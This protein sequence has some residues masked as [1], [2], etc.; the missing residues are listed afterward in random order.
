VR[1]ALGSFAIWLGL[2]ASITGIVVL[3][4]GL[5]RRDATLLRRGRLA[6]FAVCASG[7][8]ATI[9][10]QWALATDDFSLRYLAEHHAR[11]TEFPF[12]VTTM[13]SAL[14]G[15]ILLWLLVL[16]T[17]LTAMVVRFRDRADDA[18]VAWATL[19]GLV[20]A[21]FFEFLV[22]AAANPFETVSPVPSDGPG[23]NPLLQ[24]H[25]LVTLHPP[26]LYLGYVGFTIPF[27]FAIGAL[28]TGRVGEGWLVATRRATLIAWGFLT[29]G[30]ILGGWWS[31]EVLGWGGF[32]AWDPVEN[33]SLL[34]WLTATAFLHS[35]VVQER[36]GMLRVWNLSLVVATFALTIFGTFL[37]RS[38]V[39]KSVHSFSSGVGPWLM[40]FF[41]FVIVVSVGLIAWRGDR[42][43]A[44]GRIDA[45]VSREAAFLGNNLLFAA[46]AF[47]VLLGTT[48]PL[49]AEVIDGSELTVGEPY[50]NS[51]TTPLGLM[52]LFLMA[53]APALPW[54][55]AGRDVL[56]RRLVI[57]AWVGGL[58]MVALLALGARGVTPLL[59]FG[60]GA[61]TAATVVRQFALGVGARRRASGEAW[62]RATGRTVRSNPRL[63]GGQIVHLG[64]V[65]V[66]IALAASAS[67]STEDQRPLLPG[68]SMS[69][70]GY[71]VTYLG[72]EQRADDV[73]QT[74]QARL[75]VERGGDDLG[76]W[77]PALH[78]YRASGMVVPTPSVRTSLTSDLYLTLE[79]A[80]DAADAAAVIGV[81]VEPMVLWL[82]VG[83]GVMAL[84]TLVALLP[85]LRRPSRRRG[86]PDTGR[87]LDPAD[88]APHP[89]TLEPQPAGAADVPGDPQPE[90]AEVGA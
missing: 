40:G 78:A 83:G 73:R 18:L 28:V 84:G 85:S 51:M 16:G 36:R 80:P 75:Q 56:R 2:A 23:P 21:A 63:Y 61:F 82:W 26:A 44:P 86:G 55:A 30:I 9:A 70:R 90:P 6:V 48:F 54:R 37:T 3:A 14:E 5:Q 43:R 53:V 77:A 34:P 64:V 88:E 65:L 62:P 60:L 52:I 24:D 15:S 31:Y 49:L 74:I 50:F 38:G 4:L 25:L 76:V 22:L 72:I 32:W 33:A 11:A 12:T 42:L 66:A 87:R 20:V 47:V 19:T 89:D 29:V 8:L 41:L 46:F 58:T 67:Y 27:A 79:N 39:L 13:W 68:E 81:R 59:T 69:V 7:V 1:A 17:Y 35:V 45:P 10:I 57:P 71:T